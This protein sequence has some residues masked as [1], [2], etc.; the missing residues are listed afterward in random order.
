[1]KSIVVTVFVALAVLT[2]ACGQGNVFSLEVGTCFDDQDSGGGEVSDVPIVD[3]ADPHDDEVYYLFDLPS[4]DF[5]GS[6]SIDE[7]AGA[8]CLAAFEPYVAEPYNTSILDI[9]WL[10]PTP[11]SWDQG[12]REIVCILYD[13]SLAKLTGSMQGSGV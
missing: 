1:M 4:G 7:Q 12:D 11:D 5:P 10:D 13:L 6:S 8:G 2:S 3:C 9:G